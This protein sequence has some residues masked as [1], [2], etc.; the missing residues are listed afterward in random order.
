MQ[1]IVTRP[2]IVASYET[3]NE[4]PSARAVLLL[5]ALTAFVSVAASTNA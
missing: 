4:T 3:D 5:F 2:G 1:L